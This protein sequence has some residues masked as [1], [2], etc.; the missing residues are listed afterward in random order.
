VIPGLQKLR[1]WDCPL[2]TSIPIIP[3]MQKL[4][5]TQCDVIEIP[6]IAGLKILRCWGCLLLKT[7]PVIPGLKELT[8]GYCPLLTSIPMIPGLQKLECGGCPWL[9]YENDDYGRNITALVTLQRFCR[10]NLKY[11]RIKNWVGSVACTEWFYDPQN[12]GGHKQIQ[13]MGKFLSS[14]R[15]T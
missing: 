3:G 14:L 2:L 11:W 8:C 15:A 5:M 12:M 6:V 9:P 7:I 13:R 4:D 1:C 10:K